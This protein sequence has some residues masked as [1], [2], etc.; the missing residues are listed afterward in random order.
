LTRLPFS[1]GRRL[2]LRKALKLRTG[3]FRGKKKNSRRPPCPRKK[4]QR[5]EGKGNISIYCRQR[6]IKVVKKKRKKTN[7]MH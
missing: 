7:P 5:P 6:E 1:R 2:A 3:T 4:G